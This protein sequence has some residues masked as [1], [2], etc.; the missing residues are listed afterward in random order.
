MYKDTVS[1]A[2]TICETKME[3]PLETEFLIPDY[4]PQVFKIVKCFVIPVILQKQ[5]S[6][7]R[8]SV[9]G[10]LR[11]VVYY[12]ADG[13]GTLCQTEQK[14][15]FTKQAECR[16]G[17]YDLA[18]ALVETSGEVEYVNC[19]AVSGRRV[20]VRGAFILS[21]RAWAQQQAE[22]VTALAGT[23]V[24]QKTIPLKSTRMIAAAEKLI[25]AEEAVRFDVQPDMILNVQCFGQ[26]EDLKLIAGKAVIKGSLHADV[27]YRA[28]GSGE[29]RHTEVEVPFNEVL[30]LENVAEDCKGQAFADATGC[31]VTAGEEG[32]AGMRLNVTASLSAYVWKDT[33]IL[34]VSDAF[35]AQEELE[36]TAAPVLLE[37]VQEPFAQRV[38]ANTS[39]QL[40][41][42]A[43]RVLDAL[44]TP[45]SAE[46]VSENGRVVLR[47]RV[48]AH[49]LCENEMGE[50]DC[51]DKMCEYA[52]PL[53]LQASEAGMYAVCRAGIAGV[54][55]H[56]SGD[57]V[58]AEIELVVS[59][60]VSL[61]EECRAV[62][63]VRD[64]GPREKEGRDLA[65]HIYFAQ[66]GEA[67][68]DIAKH[69]A[70]PPEAIQRANG[71]EA[72]VLTETCRLLIPQ[73][74]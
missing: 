60:T 20:D 67:L 65:L 18:N 59:G 21:V 29:L 11:C 66:Q 41:D 54:S 55:A 13:D 28:K 71:L 72:D 32:E 39:G 17:E 38:T 47:G 58:T 8:L 27:L 33:E 4:L 16:L 24:Y 14:L 40:P 34:A 51:Y 74:I 70:A 37:R 6:A 10:Y 45:I 57:E 2:Q 56:K 69:Y 31:T 35:A 9:E 63:G 49:V 61:M 1:A 68:F 36:L 53:E 64:A 30:D 42:P 26:T 22:V 12:Q 73:E 48:M 7:G 62:S 25:S 23:G 52:A 19:R 5:V 15:T 44:A 46:V 50:I 43:A 3:L